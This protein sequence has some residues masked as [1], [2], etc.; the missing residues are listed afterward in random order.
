MTELGG[1]GL[2][3]EGLSERLSIFAIHRALYRALGG[4]LVGRN[5][6]IL[7][8]KGRRTGGRRSTPLFF[9]RAD[10]DYVVIASN[11]GED[12]FPGWWHNIRANPDVEIEVGR[13]RI[14]CRAERVS[15]AEVP[16]LL[17]KLDRVYSGYARYAARTTR[18][19][20]L[21][22]LKPLRGPRS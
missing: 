7:T 16:S 9:V 21:F 4:R 8:T 22:R 1:H 17:A 5:V 18:E 12:R 3:W 14:A 10:G 13:A 20:T 19:L 2:R 11:G 15:G 6:L